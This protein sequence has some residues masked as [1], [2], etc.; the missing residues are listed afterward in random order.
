MQ[1]KPY[2]V[3]RVIEQS[4]RKTV[5]FLLATVRAESSTEARKTVAAAKQVALELLVTR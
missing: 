3:Y 4:E 1:T 2:D 5:L